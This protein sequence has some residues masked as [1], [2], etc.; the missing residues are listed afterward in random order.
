MN[1][2]KNN[3][4]KQEFID[5]CCMCGY[6]RKKTAKKYAEEIGKEFFD[7]SDFES[8]FRIEARK[9]VQEKKYNGFLPSSKWRGYEA[10]RTTKH[11]AAY[12][13]GKEEWEG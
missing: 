1:D 11:L 3:M 9:D 7:E 4:D 10:A 8:V 12:G 5:R 13:N 2:Y 6:C